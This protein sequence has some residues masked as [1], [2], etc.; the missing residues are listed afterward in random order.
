[1]SSAYVYRKPVKRSP[2]KE[3]KAYSLMGAIVL[4]LILATG[5]VIYK[6]LNGSNL[7][8]RPKTTP[9][10]TVISTGS[11][12]FMSPYFQFQD[13]GQWVLDKTSTTN[14]RFIYVKYQGQID[15]A[16]LKIYVNQT[17]SSIDI[18]SPR[19]LPVRLVNDQRFQVTGVSDPC[20]NK[21]SPG[22]AHHI[23][24]VTV[25]GTTLLCDPDSTAY[26][27]ILSA[28]GGDYRLNM[29]RP[30]GTPIQ[31]A[32]IYQDNTLSP[33]SDSIL[34]IANSFQTR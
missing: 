34:N 1:M 15:Q 20:N 30:D 5:Y 7:S 6:N 26:K 24:E 3:F 10:T 18:Q 22:Q 16:V 33:K 11:H 28:E 2:Y 14:T 17:P 4:V 23:Q 19:V 25:N 9:S 8:L 27:V 21:F 29:K 12:T 13:Q 32:I 31:V